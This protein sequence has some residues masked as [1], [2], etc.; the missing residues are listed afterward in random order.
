MIGDP[1]K[2]EFRRAI[3][4]MRN[5]HIVAGLAP[6][7]LFREELVNNDDFRD[8]GGMDDSTRDHFLKHLLK[9]DKIRR[10]ITYNPE[11]ADLGT[12]IA[13]A[14]DPNGVIDAGAAPTGGDKIQGQSGGLFN[15]PW[16]MAGTDENIPLM[17]KLNMASSN[18]IILLNAI[19][20][21][22]VTWTRIES[23]HRTQFI[24]SSDSMRIYGNYQQIF[25]W[26]TEFGGDANR[27]DVANV[28]ATDEPLGPAS[29][30]NRLTEDA[31][32]AAK[33]VVK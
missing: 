16:D 6:L 18:G 7:F 3:I 9:A 19:N 1:G 29:A 23:R 31:P 30:P 26:L 13:K 25:T 27:V 2:E 21:A 10:R 8:R 22:I 14:I 32:A 12:E 15:L 28:R 11:N 33:P 17:S 20:Q 5:Q 24:T 4:E